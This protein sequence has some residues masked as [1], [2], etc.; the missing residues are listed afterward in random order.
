M[1]TNEISVV[2]S[3]TLCAV[4]TGAVLALFVQK[5]MLEGS[6]SLPKSKPRVGFLA[7]GL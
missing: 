3:L 4:V 2:A 5:M 7:S 1:K 6:L